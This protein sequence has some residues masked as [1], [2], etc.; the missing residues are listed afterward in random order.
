MSDHDFHPDKIQPDGCIVLMGMAGAGKSTVGALL[1]QEL[2]WAHVD[3][4]RLMEAYFGAML[5]QLMDNFGLDGF[6][7]AEDKLVSSM[8]LNRA[9]ISTGGSVVYGQN[10]L[11]KLK[12]LGAVV[13]LRTDLKTLEHRIQTLNGRALAIRPGQDF[14]SLWAERQPLYQAAA[15]LILD[16]D[17]RTPEQCA[18]AVIRWLKQAPEKDAS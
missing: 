4:D 7:A 13:Y 6:L 11:A 14:A 18:E 3:T 5:Q 9:V 16:T 17:E 12:L 2:G 15:D 8:G 10:A 1:A